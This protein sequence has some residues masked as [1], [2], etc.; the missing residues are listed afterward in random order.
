MYSILQT[1]TAR[2]LWKPS[3]H[4]SAPDFSTLKT[5]MLL[6]TTIQYNTWLSRIFLAPFPSS[7]WQT[8]NFGTVQW[9]TVSICNYLEDRGT[10]QSRFTLPFRLMW[11]PW[12]IQAITLKKM[13]KV[14][15]YWHFIKLLKAMKPSTLLQ[16]VVIYDLY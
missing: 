7:F 10:L 8:G 14:E 5:V 6:K 2:H 11:E 13:G 3:N 16:C 1:G 15:E 9:N 12:N 4:L